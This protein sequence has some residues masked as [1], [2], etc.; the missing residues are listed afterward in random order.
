MTQLATSQCGAAAGDVQLGDD[1]QRLYVVGHLHG[2]PERL[3]GLDDWIAAD[4]EDLPQGAAVVLHAG[5][6]IDKGNHVP[7]LLDQLALRTQIGGVAV[8]YLMGAHEWLLLR[9]LDGDR[10]AGL[11]WLLSGAEASLE[12]WGAPTSS[13]W[14]E[15]LASTIPADHLAFLRRLSMSALHGQVRFA[16]RSL[17]EADAR[18]FGLFG[19]ALGLEDQLCAGQ[20]TL[21]PCP[22]S[23][24]PPAPWGLRNVWGK[25]RTPCIVLQPGPS[26]GWRTQTLLGQGT[27]AT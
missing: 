24:T 7:E 16:C 19:Q 9:A 17:I 5:G 26:R 13:D 23:Q 4:A 3:A 2:A 8:T 18:P 14:Q 6:Y 27:A 11:L 20:A 21:A 1:V 15:R 10:R 22:I 25:G 12:R